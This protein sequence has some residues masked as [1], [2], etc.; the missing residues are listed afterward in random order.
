MM[1][2]M[3]TFSISLA[4]GLVA[5]IAVLSCSKNVDMD[6][7]VMLPD[8]ISAEVEG[9]TKMTIIDYQPVWRMDDE[10]CVAGVKY[11]CTNPVA[12]V[13]SKVSGE[14]DG[15]DTCCYP[16][17]LY[18]GNSKFCLPYEYQQHTDIDFMPMIGHYD[19]VTQKIF[20]KNLGAVC[21]F[22]IKNTNSEQT[23]YAKSLIITPAFQ[24][25]TTQTTNGMFTV[26]YP[27]QIDKI[28]QIVWD[29]SPGVKHHSFMVINFNGVV[30]LNPGEYHDV[31]A[32]LP[33]DDYKDLNLRTEAY[34]NPECTNQAY[35]SSID[36]GAAT[37]CRNAWYDIA[38][39]A[40]EWNAGVRGNGTTEAPFELG[41]VED[42]MYIKDQIKSKDQYFRQA[43]YS[44]S[45]DITINQDWN[46][47][48]GGSI[49]KGGADVFSGV[50]DGHGHKFIITSGKT[51]YRPLFWDV[52]GAVIKNLIIEGDF[53]EDEYISKFSPFF[54][55]AA[56]TSM[57]ACVFNGK[58]ET[59]DKE[60]CGVY[61]F[62][63]MNNNS[64][65]VGCAYDA[66]AA[67]GLYSEVDLEG[68][69]T[70]IPENHIS[71]YTSE[72]SNVESLNAALNSWNS[73]TDNE[74]LRTDYRYQWKDGKLVLT[75]A[76]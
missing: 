75:K 53:Y 2:K 46:E 48:I 31:Y 30:T 47:A 24:D 8:V 15:T 49:D 10:I 14:Y 20:F 68:D 13:F 43:V 1:V 69:H 23:V 62:G 5:M 27:S 16:Y 4:F 58:V 12:G 33:P 29:Y 6:P 57:V 71:V 40:S 11:K 36:K 50:F 51:G 60:D 67:S 72:E 65:L 66:T 18:Q 54:Y 3:K 35:F 56:Q 19:A 32:F 28:P 59:W 64:Y 73:S 21:R 9:T 44:L 76:N 34:F 41:C 70:I 45:R 42:I 52:N 38:V 7:G 17:S 74:R 39:K 55:C 61:V 37:V 25:E 26:T 63:A 22:R